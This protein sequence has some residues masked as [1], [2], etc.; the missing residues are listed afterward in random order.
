[1]KVEHLELALFEITIGRF[2]DNIVP[3]DDVRK[4]LVIAKDA[5][6]AIEKTTLY[7][8][9]YVTGVK[10]IG[11]ANWGIIPGQIRSSI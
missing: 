9:E 7:E 4:A 10:F 1:M 6:G 5:K 8:N 11:R 3:R 2:Y